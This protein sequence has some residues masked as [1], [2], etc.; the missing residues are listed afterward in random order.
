VCVYV[1]VRA[2]ARA[3]CVWVRAY[4]CAC[5]RGGFI[6]GIVALRHCVTASL[7]HCVT[8]S[9]CRCT[10][11]PRH[12]YTAAP[13]RHGTDVPLHHSHGTAAPLRHC[14][15][16]PLHLHNATLHV[17]QQCHGAILQHCSDCNPACCTIPCCCWVLHANTPTH[18]QTNTRTHGHTNTRTSGAGGTLLQVAVLIE[19]ESGE[20]A[21]DATRAAIPEP[22][23]SGPLFSEM[24]VGDV[25]LACPFCASSVSTTT[26][27]NVCVLC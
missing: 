9:L 22:V 17:V 21:D 18:Q 8:M 13:L 2:R 4:A 5:E 14:V 16:A 27:A 24:E 12:R 23:L 6:I 10:T 15:A 25:T 1:C 11:P 20:P 7:R 3:C 19:S 26:C